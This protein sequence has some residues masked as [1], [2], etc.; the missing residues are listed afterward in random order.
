MYTLLYSAC[1]THDACF[2][3]LLTPKI[4]IGVSYAPSGAIK[5]TRLFDAVVRLGSPFL[6]GVDWNAKHK[7]WNN[8]A[9]NRAGK[10]LYEH[11]IKHQYRI[12]HSDEFTHQSGCFRPSLIDYFLTD[13]YADFKCT[14]S[15]Y[16]D[17]AHR[18][19]I[20]TSN[21]TN[22][23]HNLASSVDW[24]LYRENT[25]RYNIRSGFSST[26]EID[27]CIKNLTK[28]LHACRRGA[29]IPDNTHIS[30]NAYLFTDAILNSLIRHRRVLR[31]CGQILGSIVVAAEIR[32]ISATIRKRISLLRMLDWD[33]TL[34]AF[35]KPDP[36]FWQTYKKITS[37]SATRT[38]PPLRNGQVTVTAD[39]EKS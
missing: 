26:Q 31:R 39:L 30:K 2:I 36:S 6:I 17:T 13:F 34:R 33:R 15:S 7:L 1:I 37:T 9:D 27:S 8:F 20:L 28:F 38:L 11:S 10:I 19:V 5:D 25:A 35:K 12:V 32:D 23:P 4:I 14:I 21:Q 22:G 3:K 16:F 24:K 18:P 29:A